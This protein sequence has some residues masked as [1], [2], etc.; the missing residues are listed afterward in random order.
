MLTARAVTA[1]SKLKLIKVM[2][3]MKSWKIHVSFCICACL[4]GASSTAETI[5]SLHSFSS[6]GGTAPWGTLLE[7]KDGL[8]Y[9]TA[10]TGGT[11]GAGTI[12]RISKSGVYSALFSF[13]N[14]V[15]GGMPTAGLTQARD[16]NFYGTAAGGG[17]T[18]L[19]T[20]FRMTPSGGFTL[21]HTFSGT[22]DGAIPFGGL[23][24]A[25]DGFLYGTTFGGALG[26]G[27]VYRIN[28]NGQFTLLHSFTNGMDGAKPQKVALIQA[29]DGYLYG[30]ASLGGATGNGT[31]FR[32]ST[33]G[34]FTPIYSF[35]NGVDG[36]KPFAGLTQG[37]DGCLYGTASRGGL[38]G[39]G[40]VYCV[41]TNGAFETLYSFANGADLRYP[42]T[43]LAEAPDGQF[44]GTVSGGGNQLGK[45]FA[46]RPNGDFRTV[47]AFTLVT[48]GQCGAGSRLILASDGSFYGT[49]AGGGTNSVG[50]IF[51]LTGLVAPAQPVK[52]E[53]PRISGNQFTFEFPTVSN[54]NY[55][56][57]I[58]TN[59]TSAQ[60]LVVTNITGNGT[61]FQ[62][63]APTSSN[64]TAFF[65]V[66]Q[67]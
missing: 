41:T 60:W 61:A 54:R 5:D 56:V 65:R 45:L 3:D 17:S 46:I 27:S 19:G 12:F 67:L 25:S 58:R 16:G 57:E 33:A 49:A 43:G 35:S 47:L 1:K 23:V 34:V 9:G 48:G 18:M 14:G 62:F 30:T 15:N 44:Y 20:V 37:R 21:L 63:V 50:T 55:A 6:A 24:E 31:V 11:Y 4:A 22:G 40:T 26:Y 59:L 29:S 7:G 52:I 64:P 38:Y 8:L 39:F 10:N 53:S 2:E 13:D 28:T 32:V 42:D 36:G 51:R 66:N